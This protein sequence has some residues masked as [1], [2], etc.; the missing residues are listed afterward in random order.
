MRRSLPLALMLI[1]TFSTPAWPQQVHPGA[2]QTHRAQVSSHQCGL[3]TA[4][5]VLADSG[6]IW[7]YR[8][9]GVPREVFFHAGELSIDHQVQQISAADSE[10]LRAMEQHTRALMPQ[11]ADMAHAVVD[12]S[13]D[14]LGGVIEVLTGSSLNARKITRLRK[15]A[16]DYVD[17]TLGK[18]R[19]DQQAFDGNFERYVE[20]EAEA[21]KGSIA[22][23]MLWQIMTGRSDAIDARAK[24]MDG[25]L[26]ARLDARAR[27]IE[28]RASALCSDV[29]TLRALQD[30]LDV[31]YQ[32]HALQ[33]LDAMPEDDRNTITAAARVRTVVEK[34]IAS[35]GAL[36]LPQPVK[37]QDGTEDA[38]AAS[39]THH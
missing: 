33:L 24:A 14:A 4:F 5:N 25:Q 21:F 6:G 18:G 13:Y 23:H 39:V 1:A 9:S 12:L 11:V 37:L 3:G 31:R 28:A 38:P 34:D 30:A 15:R 7:L 16:N 10:R 19:W 26:D 8:D 2:S 35:D 17:G 20:H 29:Q 27:A 36:A 32:G 22:R